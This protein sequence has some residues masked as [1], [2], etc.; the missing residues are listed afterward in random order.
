MIVFLISCLL[1]M[2]VAVIQTFIH[3]QVHRPPILLPIFIVSLIGFTVVI[4]AL[5]FDLITKKEKIVKGK[6]LNIK[7]R[8]ITIITDKRES[9]R[10]KIFKREVREVLEPEQEIEITL[11]M[12]TNYPVSIKIQNARN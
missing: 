11:T 3:I 5:L 7:G 12:L 6:I 10:Y 9:K 4:S 8:I 2:A 1:G